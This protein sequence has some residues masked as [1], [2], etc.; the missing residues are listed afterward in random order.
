MAFVH[1]IKLR[2]MNDVL[3]RARVRKL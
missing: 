1:L 2:H 3:V